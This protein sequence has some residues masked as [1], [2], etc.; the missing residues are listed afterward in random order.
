MLIIEMF[1]KRCC[2]KNNPGFILGFIFL[3]MMAEI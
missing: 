2:D 1:L 3:G